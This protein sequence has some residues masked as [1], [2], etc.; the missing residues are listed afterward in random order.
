VNRVFA[1][2]LLHSAGLFAQTADTA[3]FRVVMLP[4]NEI[5]LVNSATRGTADILA[6]VVRDS[7]GQIVSGTVDILARV[8]FAAAATATS[9]D[10][11]SG[12]TGQNGAVV[13]GT[14]LSTANARPI[15]NGGDTIHIAA[16]ISGDNPTP[17]A[18][19]RGLIQ[20]PS[21]YYVNLLTAD[22]PNGA[23]RGQLQRAQITVL[24]GL[25]YSDNVTAAPNNFAIGVAQVIAIGTTDASGNWTSGEV[26]LS[27]TYQSLDPTAFTGFHIHTGLA[28]TT[29]A[30]GITSTLPAGLAP[31]PTGSAILGPV[32]TEVTLSNATQAGT[33]ANLFYNPGSLYIDVHTTSNQAGVARAQLRPTD[34]MS[35]P[36]VLDS[37][38]EVRP[39]S[40]QAMAI[41]TFTVSTLRN[42]DGS[43]AAGTVLSDV[44][45]RFSGPTQFIGLYLRD[46]PSQKD[47]PASIKLVP[48]FHADTGFGNY[49][50]WSLPVA[51]PAA[52]ED[53]LRNPENHYANLHTVNDP[54]GA[55]RAQLAPPVT[56][57][58]NVAAV[59]GGNLDKN[60]TTVAPGELISIFGTHLAKVATDLKGWAGQK[61]PTLLNGVK[62]QIAGKPAP[63]LYV[64]PGQINAQVPMEVPAGMQIVLVDNGNGAGVSY[65]VNVAPVAPAIFF[66]P[67]AA[68][69][70]NANYSLVSGANPAKAGDVILIYATGLGQTSPD[71]TTGTLLPVG[72]IAQTAP[73]SVTIGGKPATVVY[74]I[75]APQFA[76]LYQVAVTVPAGVPGSV[77]VV[78]QQGNGVSNTVNIAVQ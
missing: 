63:L 65:A 74:S 6:N 5:P 31:D 13:I 50:N 75:A 58:G 29:G 68:V 48:D 78:I 56:A 8:T 51:N 77:P 52:L 3:F 2:L 1:Y 41:A 9:L 69:L 37:A 40:G 12:T 15:L 62:V 10:I 30:I 16:Q 42:E 34:S 60:A 47:G 28:G 33:F 71:M 46:A 61:L 43:V 14:G 22:L 24:M 19:L 36:V 66:S 49:Y 18:A 32:N 35:F 53:V 73:V 11:R 17:L 4:T 26:Y 64:S 38:N 72:M 70:K 20:D 67:V 25:M 39:T 59:I 55:V 44:D 27:A 7:S 45:Y 23:I 21:K 57:P 54:G 76:G